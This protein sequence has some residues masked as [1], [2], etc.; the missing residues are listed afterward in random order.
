MKVGVVGT[1]YWGKNLVR[2]MFELGYL[3]TICDTDRVHLDE[4]GQKYPGTNLETDLDRVLDDDEIMGTVIATPAETHYDVTCRSLMAGKHVMVEKPLALT[5]KEAQELVALAEEKH[6]VLMVGHLLRYHPGIRKLKDIIDNDMLGPIEYVYSHRLNLG[7]VRREEN[8]WWSFAPHDISVILMLL[9]K[10]PIQVSTT[11]GAY[12]QPNIADITVSSLLFE[13]GTRGHI[14]VSWLHP[15]KEQKLI[16]IG[17]K[18]MAVFDDVAKTEKLMIYDKDIQI[19]DGSFV[20]KKPE[21]QTVPFD[22]KEPL[23]LECEHFI[24]CMKKIQE[25]I[26]DGIEG[27]RVLAV[28]QACQRSLLMNGQPVTYSENLTDINFI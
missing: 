1:G 25:P 21:G 16:V 17:K 12:L 20:T 27:V 15:Y 28:L 18:A 2:N 19:V 4:I 5:V 11:G 13:N 9:G 22:M 7:K 6:R 14:F 26:T 10:L 23:R 3:Q 8:V 24:D